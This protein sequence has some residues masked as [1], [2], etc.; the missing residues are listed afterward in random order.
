MTC[1]IM[2]RVRDR[3]KGFTG[4][5]ADALVLVLVLRPRDVDR[6]V[7]QDRVHLRPAGRLGQQD[8]TA[9]RPDHLRQGLVE[10]GHVLTALLPLR[11]VA[12]APLA[13]PRP[14]VVVLVRIIE[15]T[16]AQRR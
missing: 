16:V 1:R 12:A 8:R 15:A 5:M 4:E 11:Q 14:Q 3:N 7:P 9:P 2:Y 10:R 6:D 13:V